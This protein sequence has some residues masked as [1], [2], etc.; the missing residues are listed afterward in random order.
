MRIRGPIAQQIHDLPDGTQ[1][2]LVV[3]E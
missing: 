2:Q 3:K 1:I